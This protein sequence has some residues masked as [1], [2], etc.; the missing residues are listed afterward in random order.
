MPSG[1]LARKERLTPPPT[2]PPFRARAP[3]WG[4]DL[5][6][7]R[8]TLLRRRAD[9]SPWPAERLEVPLAD[10]DT[11]LALR[12]RPQKDSG[13]PSLLLIHGLSGCEDS[14]YLL[15]SA[16]HFLAR[17]WPVIRLNLR[18]A[19]PSARLCRASY[20]A[21]RSEDLRAFLAWLAAVDPTAAG[22]GVLPLG[23][24]LGGN[25]LLK[26][27]AEGDFPL[28]VPAAASVSAPIDLQAASDT[29]QRPRNAAY[30][31][32]LLLNLRRE[33]RQ[34]PLELAPAER[35]RVLGQTTVFGFDDAWTAPRNGFAGARDYYR[36]CSSAPLLPAITTPSLLIHARD[37]PWIPAEAY[38]DAER[39]P[40]LR[41]L[42]PPSG[43]HVG[44]HAADDP[45]PWHDR[46]VEA[47]F[48]A[49]LG[50]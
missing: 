26:F 46:C 17:G 12:Q 5:Q 29:I 25:L 42:L 33:F 39:N 44:F 35:R 40:A 45:Q 1:K 48:A 7:L 14:L 19:G 41:L 50:G 27:L 32:Y 37:D 23:Y 34:S 16:R 22:R 9:L 30:Q 47:F 18:G 36:R 31:R 3:W 24:S 43:G 20:H 8:N 10:G 13:R 11:L 49:R 28:P 21:G 2:F 38:R 4:G 15:A 6:T